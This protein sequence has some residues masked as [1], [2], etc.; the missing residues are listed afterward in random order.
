M[1]IK[2]ILQSTLTLLKIIYKNYK[3]AMLIQT[4][5]KKRVQKWFEHTTHFK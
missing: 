4:L 5:F 2:N 3:V 1:K